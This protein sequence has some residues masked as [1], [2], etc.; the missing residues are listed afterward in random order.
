MACQLSLSL[1]L[2]LVV[3][4][5]TQVAAEEEACAGPVLQ[6]D[7]TEPD[8]LRTLNFMFGL[9]DDGEMPPLF[10]GQFVVVFWGFS[11][12][13]TTKKKLTENTENLAA[14]AKLNPTWHVKVWNETGIK[15][16]WREDFPAFKAVWAKTSPIQR[17]DLA[18]VMIVLKLGGLYTDL[19]CIPTQSVD[20]ILA[21]NKFDADKHHTVFC[22]ED[23][24]T[25]AEMVASA[26]WAIRRGSIR[27]VLVHTLSLASVSTCRCARVPDAHC[28]LRVLG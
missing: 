12:T 8:P 14:W 25:P 24:K 26:R 6:A 20:D 22:V 3:V 1:L 17:A 23:V 18:R 15:T 9:W 28:Q 19:D 13:H 4:A 10:Q 27:T 7:A 21:A 2:L 5:A 16:L 11:D